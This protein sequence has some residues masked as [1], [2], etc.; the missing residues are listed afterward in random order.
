MPSV[1]CFILCRS[2]TEDIRIVILRYTLPSAQVHDAAPQGGVRAVPGHDRGDGG[3]VGGDRLADRPVDA[4]PRHHRHRPPVQTL[5]VRLQGGDSTGRKY[6]SNAENIFVLG[7]AAALRQAEGVQPVAQER[8]A[9]HADLSGADVC[10]AL[11]LH[12][13]IYISTYICN[14]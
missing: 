10:M 8:S 5:P 14:I 9:L 1:P 2:K 6:L 13:Y 12:I 4:G 11:Y 3:G 7:P